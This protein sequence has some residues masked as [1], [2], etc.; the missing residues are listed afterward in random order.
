MERCLSPCRD[1]RSLELFN[2]AYRDSC[3]PHQMI[4]VI[5]KLL[6]VRR[7]SPVV[8][9]WQRFGAVGHVAGEAVLHGEKL[10]FYPTVVVNEIL[11]AK[12]YFVFGAQL[13]SS[14][15]R[16]TEL[17]TDEGVNVYEL[18]LPGYVAFIKVDKRPT[19]RLI[20]NRTLAPGKPLV[21]GVTRSPLTWPKIGEFRLGRP[22]RK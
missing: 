18:G 6:R 7:P 12:L 14:T 10:R 21:I 1:S 15:L 19:P 9:T 2:L 20:G 11:D 13:D 8:S 22:H 5:E 16:P 3:N 4:S 17:I